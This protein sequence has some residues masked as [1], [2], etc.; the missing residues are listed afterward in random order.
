MEFDTYKLSVAAVAGMGFKLI[1]EGPLFSENHDNSSKAPFV[2]YVTRN[3]IPS[4]SI[5]QVST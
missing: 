1:E 3:Q 4:L 5:S 2:G